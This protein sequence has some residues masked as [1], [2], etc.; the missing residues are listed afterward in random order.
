LVNKASQKRKRRID[1]KNKSPQ[2]HSISV[3][4]VLLEMVLLAVET[5]FLQVSSG[6]Y[7]HALPT[8][9]VDLGIGNRL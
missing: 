7:E 5:E 1:F 4:I 2:R 6:I 8:A 9:N 3:L